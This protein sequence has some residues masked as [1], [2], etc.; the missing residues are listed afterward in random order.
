[1]AYS[2]EKMLNDN[3][4]KIPEETR[5]EIE[6]KIGVLRTALQGSDVEDIKAKSQEL[7]ELMQKAGASV[8]GQQGGQAEP[9]AQSEQTEEEPK[10]DD[11]GTVE[12]EFREV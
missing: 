3:K 10:K 1:M 11:E 9:G 6:D 7:S 8:Y 5:K 2:A 12:G 4:D